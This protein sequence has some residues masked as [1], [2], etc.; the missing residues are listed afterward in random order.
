MQRGG[1]S[2]RVAEP[3]PDRPG[4]P[5]L[6]AISECLLGR[7]VRYDG[8]SAKSSFPHSLFDGL[9]EY[10]GI[11]P[12]VGIG[13]GTP[14][15]PIRL[16][17]EDEAEPRVVGVVDATEDYTQAL[18]DY[19]R[20]A[21]SQL[22]D[23]AGYVFMKNSP[24]CGVFR[25]KV[26]PPGG[27]VPARRGRGAH[28]RAVMEALPDLPV[29]EN[30]RLND[31]TLRESFVTRVFAYR[32]WQACFGTFG[33]DFTSAEFADSGLL[34]AHRLIEFHS[35]YKYLL[36][37]HSVPHYQRAGRLLS[38]LKHDLVAKAAAYRSTLMDGLAQ[39]ASRN[40]HANVL[41]HLQGYCKRYLDSASRQE[42]H[43]LVRGY[44]RGEQPL[45]APLTLL[46]HHL[47]RFP[48]EYVLQQAYLDPHPGFPGLRRT[49]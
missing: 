43:E 3:L 41:S 17:A 15:E 48:Q 23:V 33:S 7:E 14:R 6:I 24:S 10:R 49:L 29:E 32:H 28:A 19:G 8:S 4:A 40:G 31:P 38:D 34:S 5:L 30:G 26:Y 44:Q 21:A 20:A 35:R 36:M 42:L 46:K 47:R 39:P 27:G 16:V 11:C 25:V 37:A 9:F 2:L 22:D 12:E 45:L 18:Y 13:M 1:S